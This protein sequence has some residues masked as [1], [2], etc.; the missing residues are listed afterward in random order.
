MKVLRT[1]SLAVLC[2][3]LVACASVP[4]D[5]PRETSVVISDVAGTRL[6]TEVDEWTRAHDGLSGFYPLVN[7]LDAL[8]A[9]LRLLEAAERS[10]DIQYFLMNM[11]VFHQ[12]ISHICNAH[13]L[14]SL[15]LTSY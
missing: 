10:V 14:L 15:P 13:N 2:S 4:F 5:Y 7:G 12:H 9:R 3:A 8:G 1:T 11:R 6:A